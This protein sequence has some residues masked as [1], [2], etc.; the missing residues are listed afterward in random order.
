[1]VV[2]AS[3]CRSAVTS[4]S[5]AILLQGSGH[6]ERALS[7]CTMSV[8]VALCILN[9]VTFKPFIERLMQFDNGEV[10]LIGGSLL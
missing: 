9:V 10:L 5:L 2:D 7:L 8:C 4:N 6:F 3:S 1:M